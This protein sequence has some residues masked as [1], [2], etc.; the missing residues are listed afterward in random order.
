MMIQ[1]F[2]HLD[3]KMQYNLI[4]EPEAPPF[5]QGEQGKGAGLGSPAPFSYVL[6]NMM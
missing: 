2:L 4:A 6:V 3:A 5:S 1:N